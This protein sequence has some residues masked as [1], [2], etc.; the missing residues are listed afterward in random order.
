[1]FLDPTHANANDG[2]NGTVVH[3]TRGAVLLLVEPPLTAMTMPP[4]HPEDGIPHRHG[5]AARGRRAIVVVVVV[6][7]VFALFFGIQDKFSRPCLSFR[8]ATE[9]VVPSNREHS[10][11]VAVWE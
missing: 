4:F 2:P 6:V 10:P 5:A 9:F 1:M 11:S 3:E 7:V 8:T